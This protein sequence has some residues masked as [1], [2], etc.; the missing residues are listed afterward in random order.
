[1]KFHLGSGYNGSLAPPDFSGLVFTCGHF[2]K[3]VQTSSLCNF[4]YISERNSFT[5]AFLSTTGLSDLDF[6]HAD[7]CQ[8]TRL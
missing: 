6:I 4:H 5:H 8:S 2:Q 1:M 3:I 7:F